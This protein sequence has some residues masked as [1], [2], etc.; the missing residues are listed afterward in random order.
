MNDTLDPFYT[1]LEPGAYNAV[2][3]SG[4]PCDEAFPC[5]HTHSLNRG[6]KIAVAVVVTIVGLIILGG[7]LF[8]FRLYRKNRR[9]QATK[10]VVEKTT[11]LGE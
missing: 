10:G 4:T 11:V 3:P 8:W 9:C 2:K 7:L 5:S 1:A 6:G